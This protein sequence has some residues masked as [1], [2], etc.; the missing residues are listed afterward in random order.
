LSAGIDRFGPGFSQRLRRQA[1]RR[2]AHSASRFEVLELGLTEALA[3]FE[4]TRTAAA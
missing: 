2:D 4:R 1:G 3:G